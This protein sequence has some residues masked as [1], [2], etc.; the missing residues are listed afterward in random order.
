MVRGVDGFAHDDL[1]AC[2]IVEGHG[3]ISRLYRGDGRI[4]H[5]AGVEDLGAALGDRL[6]G[7]PVALT[8]HHI[9]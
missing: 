6:Q 9:T 5:V 1:I 7:L 8:R 2:Y 3:T 4:R